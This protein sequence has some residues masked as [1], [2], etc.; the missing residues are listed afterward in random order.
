MPGPLGSSPELME[1]TLRDATSADADSV[2]RI[3]FAVLEEYGLRPDPDGVDADLVDPAAYYRAPGGS[4]FVLTTGESEVVG[5]GGLYPLTT[6]EAEIR[7]MYLLPAVRGLG[8]GKRLLERLIETAR[9]AGF[10][11]VSLETASVLREA[12]ALY[13]RR[14][15]VPAD[16]EPNVQRCD[17]AFVLDLT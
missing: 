12:I 15:F 9:A 3:V 5:C 7:K 10:R 6:E 17:R 8:L 14:G 4:F 1:L 11:R 2:R 16:H 13:Q